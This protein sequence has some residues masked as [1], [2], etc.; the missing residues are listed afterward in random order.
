MAK[1]LGIDM[2]ALAEAEHSAGLAGRTEHL[3]G[4]Q[5]TVLIAGA[6]LDCESV[7][8]SSS[9]TSGGRRSAR[10]LG[11]AIPGIRSHSRGASV[12]KQV[13]ED[14]PE[15]LR[16]PKVP[17]VLSALLLTNAVLPCSVDISQWIHRTV[18]AGV[19]I[20][21]QMYFFVR[22]FTVGVCEYVSIMIDQDVTSGASCP[23]PSSGSHVGLKTTRK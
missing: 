9:T 6:G 15:Q 22:V 19:P 5:L 21:L 4:R 23:A 18:P 8:I 20:S 13:M 14:I 17:Q 7:S 1:F 10:I 16:T 11:M 3:P 12:E 2:S